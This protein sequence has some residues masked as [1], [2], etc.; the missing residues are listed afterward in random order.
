MTG[1]GG[2]LGVAIGLGLLAAVSTAQA[3]NPCIGDAKV[4][5]TECKGDCKEAYQVA[6]DQCRNK[7]HDCMEGC[8]AG[9]AECILNSSL[10]EDLAVCR[11]TL[12]AAKQACRDNPENDT[13]AELDACI[14][15]A[16][17]TAFLCRKTARRNA[18]PAISACRAGFRACAQACPVN[19]NPIENIDRVQCKIDA[20]NAYLACKAGCREE[21]QAQKDLCLNRDHVCVEGCRAGRD[22]CRQPVEEQLDADIAACNATKTAAVDQCKLDHPEGSQERED[23]IIAALVVAFQCRD[24]AREDAKPQ[25]Q[26]CRAGFQACAEA[27]PPAS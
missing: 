2:V 5:F 9:R 18:K 6:K 19:P 8:R 4:T 16:Q 27:C 26:A 10:D 20:K 21:F 12:R 22:A 3:G 17:V 25:F 23:C 13:E 7:D 15:A 11:D 1:Q 24:Q 14:D